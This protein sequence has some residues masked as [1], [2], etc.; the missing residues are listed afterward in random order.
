MSLTQ[1]PVRTEVS[2]PANRLTRP[3]WRDPRVAIGIL[4]VAGSV[5]AGA[6]VLDAADDTVAVW[7]AARDLPAGATVEAADLVSVE[8][9]FAS[10]S[11]EDRYVSADAPPEGEVLARTVGAGELLPTAALTTAEAAGAV[12]L[13]LAVDP[14]RVPARVRAGSRVDVWVL[15][16]SGGEATLLL[17]EVPVL[18]A[19]RTTDGGGLR[20]V[21]VSLTAD[22]QRDLEALL[23]ALADGEPLVVARTS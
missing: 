9:R 21:V 5:L 17:T 4:L 8:V 22:L 19:T 2:P 7:A 15:P 1:R 13:P 14:A 23:A 3:G 18:S 6:R 20:Q 10:G 12:E 16:E 11:E